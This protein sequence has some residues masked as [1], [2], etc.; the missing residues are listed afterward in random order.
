MPKTSEETDRRKEIGDRLAG[1]HEKSR[2]EGKAATKRR[3][4][5]EAFRRDGQLERL[6]EMRSSDPQRFAAVI[7]P[8]LR[9]RLGF[10]EGDREISIAEGT[11]DPD[12]GDE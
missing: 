4:R 8:S 10:Y 6:M 3:R 7:T 11:F 1:A 5:A 12:G 9:M 2:I